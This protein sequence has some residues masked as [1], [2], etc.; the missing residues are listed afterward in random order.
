MICLFCN[1]LLLTLCQNRLCHCG[2]YFVF[3]LEHKSLVRCLPQMFH[4]AKW[5][6]FNA[7]LS[8]LLFGI[9]IIR[10]RLN[11]K[12]T[13]DIKYL[14]YLNLL[15]KTHLFCYYV[16]YR[17]VFVKQKLSTSTNCTDHILVRNILSC[18][19]YCCFFLS[20]ILKHSKEIKKHVYILY[21][22]NHKIHLPQSTLLFVKMWSGHS[23]FQIYSKIPDEIRSPTREDEL[24]PALKNYLLKRPMYSEDTNFM[25][26]N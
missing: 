20:S 14:H 6:L 7:Q 26:M 9:Q 5:D 16:W 2:L 25:N 15:W 23:C 10:H 22:A 4:F 12:F 24:N 8:L 11:C 17:V 19:V 18:F 3:K 13:I 1:V 21:K